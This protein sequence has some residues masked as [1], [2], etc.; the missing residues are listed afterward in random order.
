[1]REAKR[2]SNLASFVEKYVNTSFSGL[3]RHSIPSKDSTDNATDT[4]TSLTL[5]SHCEKRSDEAIQLLLLKS[6]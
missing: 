5:L 1:L 4:A 6:M 3:L 2:R